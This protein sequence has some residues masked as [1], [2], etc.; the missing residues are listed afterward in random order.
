MV[1]NRYKYAQVVQS[2]LNCHCSICNS[3]TGLRYGERSDKKAQHSQ[4]WFIIKSMQATLFA[5]NS[6]GLSITKQT[7]DLREPQDSE[8]LI[9]ITHCSVGR[10]DV[11][12]LKNDYRISNLRYPLTAG[13]E[14]IGTVVSCGKVAQE[15][16]APGDRV[17]VGYQI[18][19]CGTCAY[20]SSRREQLCQ[21][22]QVLVLNAQGGFA[23]HMVVD[24]R[25]VFKIPESL[26]SANT[27]PLLCSGLTVF[28]ALKRAQIEED[29]KVG[30]I[31]IGGLGHMAVQL[32]ALQCK[33]VV[34]FSGKQDKAAREILSLGASEVVVPKAK[35]SLEP[36][37]FDRLFITTPA[38][39]NYNDWLKLLKPDGELWVIGSATRNTT[40]SSG[41]LNDFANRSIQG[42]YIGSPD[43]MRELLSLA[44]EHNI[45][46]S[47]KV[48]PME[49]LEEAL[50]LVDE[51]GH[52]FRVIVANG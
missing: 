27:A 25:F 15:T 14:L 24:A 50:K 32:A 47:V 29:M 6:P 16:L 52:A 5:V 35:N 31:G 34:A 2:G 4:G 10:G 17:G 9:K 3:Q 46:G 26:E 49:D 7:V 48:M 23:S 45:K 43:E 44:D 39:I 8:V 38:V 41:L 20:C 28:S 12:F 19:S 30:I 18:W 21:Q 33:R 1:R 37:S 42:N 36:Q 22:Q 51:G 13:H 40:F 11:G